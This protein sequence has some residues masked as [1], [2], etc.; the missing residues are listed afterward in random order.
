[1]IEFGSNPP[2]PTLTTSGVPTTVPLPHVPKRKNVYVT[3]PVGV[4]PVEW[5]RVAVS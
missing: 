5:V 2:D 1:M 4:G 3:V